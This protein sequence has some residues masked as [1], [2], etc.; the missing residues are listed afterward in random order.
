MRCIKHYQETARWSKSLCGLNHGHGLSYKNLSLYL[1]AASKK[2]DFLMQCFDDLRL[3]FRFVL[4]N[5]VFVHL[6]HKML[7]KIDF[8]HYGY[9]FTEQP[10]D[11][12]LTG[13]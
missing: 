11:S 8:A 12:Y 5:R 1:L 9:R 7:Q 4:R 3:L 10:H 2:Q 13:L 6:S